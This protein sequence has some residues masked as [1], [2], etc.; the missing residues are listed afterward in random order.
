M[1]VRIA[2]VWFPSYRNV[3]NQE[4]VLIMNSKELTIRSVVSSLLDL[5]SCKHEL[6]GTRSIWIGFPNASN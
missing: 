3:T 2:Y 4:F 1:S 5:S 6:Q